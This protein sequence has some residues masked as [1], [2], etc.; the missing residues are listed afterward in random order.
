VICYSYPRFYPFM[1]RAD[2]SRV[3]SVG[4]GETPS[5]M[6]R[7]L[8]I[9]RRLYFRD[10][11]SSSEIK[12]CTGLTRKTVQRWL[13]AA[14]GAAGITCPVEER[15]RPRPAAVSPVTSPGIF[16]RCPEYYER[17]QL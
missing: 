6:V 13:K 10:G 8:G 2:S 1:L 16:R 17:G 4:K 9:I 5:R 3:I 12:R 15:I 11:L 14:E 7:N